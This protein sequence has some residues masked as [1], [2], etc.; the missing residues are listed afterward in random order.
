M[1]AGSCAELR[2]AVLPQ[3]HCDLI[4][5]GRPNTVCFSSACFVQ[6]NLNYLF[7]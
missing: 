4:S 2:L 3:V 6:G 7:R 5:L 1:D